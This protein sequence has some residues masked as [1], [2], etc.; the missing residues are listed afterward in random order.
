MTAVD[1]LHYVD[2]LLSGDAEDLAPAVLAT[3]HNF[4]SNNDNAL[5][6]D[7]PS[8]TQGKASAGVTHLRILGPH[9]ELNDYLRQSKVARMMAMC[10]SIAQPALVPKGAALAQLRRNSRSDKLKPCYQRRR[11]ARGHAPMENKPAA[12]KGASIAV[13][14]R[15]T[16]QEFLL[17][18]VKTAVGDN[19]DVTFN[20]YGLCLAG[21]VPQF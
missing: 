12:H 2:V 1:T 16:G 18:L 5:G 4:N 20:S 9:A 14:S 17:K 19:P 10:S 21:G 11:A 8:W 15:S 7:I 3:V 6:I 13:T